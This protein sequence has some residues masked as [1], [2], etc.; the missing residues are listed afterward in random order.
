MSPSPAKAKSPRSVG[1]R[2]R[3]IAADESKFKELVIYI[4]QKSASDPNFGSVK[5]NKLLFF[6]DFWAYG[7]LGHPITGV[8]YQRLD[9]GPAPRR[10]VPIRKALERDRALALQP[11]SV[12]G[13][14]IQNR[15]VNLREAN[16]DVFSAREISLVDDVINA[17]RDSNAKECSEFSHE[18]LSWKIAGDMETIPYASV[19]LS[20]EPLTQDE[21]DRGREISKQW[22]RR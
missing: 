1:G 11:T 12:A 14:Y 7:Q 19:F 4:A 15:P 20:H 2:P 3:S 21:A 16:L 5:L 9:H 17:L 8:E 13:D 22:E 6:A 18:W 10:L